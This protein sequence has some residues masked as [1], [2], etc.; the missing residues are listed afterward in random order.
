MTAKQRKNKA[1]NDRRAEVKQQR[2]KE[3][4]EAA[5]KKGNKLMEVGGLGW[6]LWVDGECRW[7]VSC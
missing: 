1:K 3:A 6:V 7:L 5:K 4:K 2:A